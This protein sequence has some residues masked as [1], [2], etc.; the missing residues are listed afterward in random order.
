MGID[1]KRL[2]HWVATQ[3][4]PHE[5]AVRAWLI[6]ARVPRDE[7]DDL[8]QE[9]YCKLLAL[10]SIDHIPR[11]DGYFFQTVRN[12]MTDKM[13]RARIVRIEALTE[14]EASSVYSDEPSPE[15]ITAARR[16]LAAV[17]EAIQGLPDRCRRVIELRKVHGVS[18]REIARR[19]GVN[20]STVE[21]EGV[22]GMRLIMRALREQNGAASRLPSKADNDRSRNRR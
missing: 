15:R 12:L 9:A 2:L 1:H 7:V 17:Q 21:N 18:Q 6:R 11:P 19:L 4:M 14:I 22:K 5:G 16:E 3:I 8:I 20:E 13:R 10:D